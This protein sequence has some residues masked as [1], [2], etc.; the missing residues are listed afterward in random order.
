MSGIAV[1]LV[2]MTSH[3][4]S[5]LNTDYIKNLKLLLFKQSEISETYSLLSKVIVVNKFNNFFKKK[6]RQIQLVPCREECNFQWYKCSF[7]TVS[8]LALWQATLL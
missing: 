6:H 8:A 3:I 7:F 2:F 4:D 5:V 1:L